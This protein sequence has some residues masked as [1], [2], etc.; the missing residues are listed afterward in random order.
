MTLHR[1]GPGDRPAV[2]RQPVARRRPLAVLPAR[3]P[4]Q[5]RPMA[6][7]EPST[8]PC[9]KAMDQQLGALFDR[10]RRRSALRDNTLIVVASDN[11]HEPGAGASDPLAASQD[12][13]LRRGR[14]FAADR[15][16]PGADRRRRS[17]H[18][19]RSVDLLCPRPQRVALLD[20]RRRPRGSGARRRGPGRHPARQGERTVAGRRSSGAARPIG[21]ERPSS[22]IPTSPCAT[23]SGSFY[24]N[25]DG[26][27]AQLYDLDGRH[28]GDAKPRRP[29][30][31][32][33]RA[34]AGGDL[35]VERPDAGR[36]GRP[37]LCEG[38]RRCRARRHAPAR[39]V[40]Q[41]DR[42]RSRPLGRSRSRRRPLPLVLFRGQPRHRD[43]HQRP[44][45]VLRAEAHR[46]AGTGR[47]PRFPAGL[48][49]RTTLPRW[50]LAHLLRRQRRA[51]REPPRLRP[52]IRTG[53]SSRAVLVARPA[54][55]RR[56]ARRPHTQHLG[57]RHD[58]AG[59]RGTP[60]RPLVR[61]G[62]PRHRPPVSLHRPDEVAG[63]VGRPPR[64]ALCQRRL[65]WERTEEGEKGRGLN[66][67]PQVLHTGQRTF[68]IYSCGASW[69]PTYKLGGLELVGANPLDPAAWNKLPR[70]LFE[71]TDQTFGVG[72]SCFV[73]SPTR[74]SG[75]MSIMPSAT[76]S[77]AGAARSWS[78]RCGSARR[79]CRCSASRSHPPFRSR[80]PAGE[81]VEMLHLPYH[82]AL[83]AEADLQGWST[84][85]H[86]QFFEP[87]GDGLHLGRVR[88]QVDQR[89]S[90]R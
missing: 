77:P 55:H 68:V 34:L 32:G 84:F 16:G 12:V 78:S 9:S 15:L 3:G 46:L 88:R 30:S 24:V 50:S 22:R 47:G 89:L 69:L 1:P 82:R 59:A 62:C 57:H 39:P 20:R 72:H 23:A 67:A 2:L 19:Q 56:G 53:R 65:P 7:S 43:P 54:G 75:G 73:Q 25:Y 6:A 51:Q 61:L 83:R 33:R 28:F 52:P 35:R 8:T 18:R 40:R 71:G 21:R 10:V 14:A 63:R 66:E 36:C 13:A 45:H 58:G 29:P 4:A 31:P 48:G 5:R 37:V 70:P 44:P 41:P 42:R 79:A 38:C 80:D 90:Q 60:I 86:H 17:R 11:G 76:A 49:S 81:P 74:A 26:T 64:A 85:G 87:S 27:G